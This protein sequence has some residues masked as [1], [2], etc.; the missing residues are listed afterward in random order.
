MCQATVWR[1]LFATV[2]LTMQ[3]VT[4]EAGNVPRKGYTSASSSHRTRATFDGFPRFVDTGRMQQ[5]FIAWPASHNIRLKC[6]ANGSKPLR[7]QWLK[8]G[9]PSIQRR[10]QP[11]LKTNMWYLKLKDL[12]TVDSGRYTCVVS[13]PFGSI[14]HTYTLRVVEKSRTKPILKCGAP[15]NTSV[16]LGQNASMTC[17]VVISGTIPDFRWV[18]W[19]SISNNYP[20]SLDFINGS[21]TLIN[22]V[23]YQTVY[24]QGKQGVQVNIPNVTVS[25][26]GLYTCYVSNHLGFDYRSAFL[27]EKKNEWSP[28]EDRPSY[29]TADPGKRFLDGDHAVDTKTIPSKGTKLSP[30]SS[31]ETQVPLSVFL[32]VLV[33]WTVT[34]A[35]GFLWC[36]FRQKKLITATKSELEC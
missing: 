32:G 23:Q 18:K 28:S 24:V 16:Q 19:N 31:Q 20:N 8:D 29:T 33:T 25:D 3:I 35:V 15:K 6:K 10:L 21:Y 1:V 17:V 27:F 9:L 13:N 30:P 14:N 11:R 34:T 7:Y 4:D 22:P 5:T 26:L 36:H 12:V 2:S